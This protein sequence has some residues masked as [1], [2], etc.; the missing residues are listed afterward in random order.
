MDAPPPPA[1]RI[2]SKSPALEFEARVGLPR[3]FAQ[4]QAAGFWARRLY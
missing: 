4:A 2:Y 3:C 1:A